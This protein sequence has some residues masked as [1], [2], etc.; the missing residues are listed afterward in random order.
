MISV[1]W[2]SACALCAASPVVNAN[3]NAQAARLAVRPTDMF[4]NLLWCLWLMRLDLLFSMLL[5]LFGGS[6]CASPQRLIVAG[7]VDFW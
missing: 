7:Y 1:I 3:P 6:F 5:R 2:S 4:F